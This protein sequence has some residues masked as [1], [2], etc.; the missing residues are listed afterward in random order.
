M[1]KIHFPKITLLTFLSSLALGLSIPAQAAEKASADKKTASLESGFTTPSNDARPRTWWHW[2]NE[3]V[4]EY[5]ITKDLEAMKR[6]GLKG[7]QI[8]NIYQ[9]GPPEAQG[10][11]VVLSPAWIKAVEHAAKECERLGLTLG[12]SSAAGCSGSG[13]PW[14]TPELSMQEIVWRHKFVKGPVNGKVTLP[15]PQTNHG[16]YRDIAILAFPTLPGD[17]VPLSAL[18]PEIT[19]NI[20][21]VDWS[22]AIDGND[23][24]FVT[25]PK[26]KDPKESAYVIFKF[27]AP[28]PIGS[29]TL[30]IEENSKNRMVKLSASDDGVNWAHSGTLNRWRSEFVPERE[31]LIEG[32]LPR[33]AKFVKVEFMPASPGVPMNLYE[34]NFQSARLEK[35]HTKAAR[36]RTQPE[37]SD[38]SKQVIPEAQQIPLDQ[39]VDLTDRLQPNGELDCNL[40]EGEWTILRFGHTTNG[41]EVKPASERAKGLEVDK[42]DAE[43][44]E[45]HVK[46]GML[47]K[48]CDFLG[49]LTGKVFVDINVDSWEAG[50]QTWTRKFLEQFSQ[51][52]GYD[53]RKWLITLTGRIVGDVDRTE[54]FLWDYRRTV[55]DLIAENFYGKLREL[56]N[57]RGI[58]LEAEAPGIGMPCQVDQIQCLGKIDIPQGEFWLSGEADPQHGWKGGQDNTKEPAVAAHVYGKKIVSC[59][60]FTSFGHHDGWTQDPYR[61][62]PVGDR[63]FCNGMNEIVF[64]R[65]AHQPDDRFPGMSLGQFGLNFERT[66]TWWEQGRDWMDY[67]TRCSYMLR[68]GRFF[69]DVCYYYG[70]DVPNSAWYFA[71]GA[72]D[73]RQR[74]KPILPNGY[75]Y[76]VCDRTILDLMRV[77]DGFVVLPSGMRYQYLVLPESARFTPGA[78]QKVYE[79]VMAG[80]T[81]I[82]PKPSTSPSLTDYP[83]ADKTIQELA[84]KLWLTPADSAEH[85][86]GKGRV[87][88][89]KSFEKILAKDGLQP[90]FKAESQNKDFEV[91]YIHRVLP[92]GHTYFVSNQKDRPEEVVVDCRVTGLVPEIWNPLTG[93]TSDVAMYQDDGTSTRVALRMENYDSQFLV[94]KKASP[95]RGAVVDLLKDGQ[96]LRSVKSGAAALPENAPSILVTKKGGLRL[97]AWEPGRYE[98]VFANGA[99]ADVDVKNIPKPEI[100]PEKWMVSF[101]KDRSAP[102]GQV[103]FDKLESWTQR[104]EDGIRY[105]SGTASYQ[106]EVNLSSDR[107]KPGNRVYLDLG[108]VRHLAEVVVNDKPVG[109]AW[110]P[111]FRVDITDA[112]K[113]GANKV[114]VRVT[115]VWKNRLIGDQKLP[116]KDRITWT[117]YPFYKADAPLVE[118]GLLGPV[119]VLSTGGNEVPTPVSQKNS[120]GKEAAALEKTNSKPLAAAPAN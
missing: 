11:D 54:R 74:M 17:A 115:N 9:G 96:S 81:V 47:G 30:Q 80:A 77:E 119:R 48:M 32:V 10:E 101:Q 111:P 42:M 103:A 46:N 70:E 15:Q 79:L 4:T 93:K 13:G 28:V 36:M 21:D 114:E 58:R 29:I 76:D 86:V 38:H 91:R 44:I 75:D 43:A 55:G 64:H 116:Q 104:P 8:T 53:G 87:I 68:E 102:E 6:I 3:N 120:P 66:L 62:K 19:S 94:F 113:P 16:Y 37:V 109:I 106:Q 33:T 92:N 5:G 27:P 84:A 34:L 88:T 7:A 49:P 97:N 14:I 61:L 23:E 20:P 78:L 107:L 85:R 100:L 117:F 56:L 31:E 112:A 25:L 83:N 69:A 118:S 52:R 73:P 105:F 99:K 90:D 40:P 98:L 39:I 45:Y 18:N 95:S 57:K 110:K 26:P 60:S 12:A 50:C 89:E 41:N 59:E 2:I 65:Y 72:I 71:P 108:D 22:A 1:T 35:I 82:G 51:R 63:Q 67:L 24:T